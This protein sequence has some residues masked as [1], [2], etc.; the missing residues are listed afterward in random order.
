M[1]LKNYTSEVAVPQ[2]INRI[3]QTLIKCGVLGIAEEYLQ[4]G[5][6]AALTFRVVDKG[7][8]FAV[9]LCPNIEGA[10]DALWTDYKSTNSRGLKRKK[11]E[12]FAE[13]AERTAWRILQDWVEIE[14]SKIQMKQ[15]D[16]TEV[17]LSYIQC[18]GE[19]YYRRLI[20]AGG[21][22]ALLA[23]KT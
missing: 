3:R 19:S 5:A 14:M 12:D 15:A 18:N 20:N 16:P 23:E 6:I 13:Q 22:K 11:R 21:Y 8:D 9:R 1:F 17:F 10:T 2:T 4:T 7:S